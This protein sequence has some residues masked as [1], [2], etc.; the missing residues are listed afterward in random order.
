MQLNRRN[1]EHGCHI[2]AVSSGTLQNIYFVTKDGMCFV[3]YTR[4]NIAK[5]SFLGQHLFH[6]P[7]LDYDSETFSV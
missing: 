5:I 1:V 4:L 3:C 7:H 6:F 2:N